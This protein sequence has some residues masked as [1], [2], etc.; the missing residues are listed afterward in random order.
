MNIKKLIVIAAA[1]FFLSGCNSDLMSCLST[2]DSQAACFA[3]VTS[4]KTKSRTGVIMTRNHGIDR[5][6]II[7]T[8]SGSTKSTDIEG[9]NGIDRG[10]I[11]D[12]IT[13]D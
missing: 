11:T 6:G 13:E 10:G 8:D 12:P 1:T 2:A 4:T 5:G 9:V 7:G 3:P